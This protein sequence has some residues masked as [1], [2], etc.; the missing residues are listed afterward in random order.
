MR[1][2]LNLDKTEVD[3]E[4]VDD[5]MMSHFV[6]SNGTILFVYPRILSVH[7]ELKLYFILLHCIEW[8]CI[9]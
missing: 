7:S 4:E 3:E 1:N 5:S 9:V 6:S 2:R 8:Y